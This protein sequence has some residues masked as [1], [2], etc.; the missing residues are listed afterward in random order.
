MYVFGPIGE[1]SGAT[2]EAIGAWG[3]V[4][5]KYEVT[6]AD[7]DEELVYQFAKWMHEN[8][9]RVGIPLT[10]I[11]PPKGKPFPPMRAE[12]TGEKLI[13]SLRKAAGDT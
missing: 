5:Y 1:G 2:P 12:L 7:A 4:G 8:G 3:T 11:F 9:F 13:D 10:I 6:R